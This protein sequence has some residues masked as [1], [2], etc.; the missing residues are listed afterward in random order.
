MSLL[1]CRRSTQ[2]ASR[3]PK[4]QSI[5]I[6]VF[7]LNTCGG[8]QDAHVHGG[9]LGGEGA[10]DRGCCRGWRRP[11]ASFSR[12]LHLNEWV[13]LDL[14]IAA[15][16][17]RKALVLAHFLLL[18]GWRRQGGA[19]ILTKRGK[20]IGVIVASETDRNNRASTS[21]ERFQ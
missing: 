8:L 5:H 11:A 12:L 20:T 6:A 4:Q 15:D 14:K 13:T 21:C 19:C 2:I 16:E 3:L 7:V 18:G 9:G 17:P 1:F 10:E